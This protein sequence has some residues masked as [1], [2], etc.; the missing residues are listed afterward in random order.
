MCQPFL[1]T[2]VEHQALPSFDENFVQSELSPLKYLNG[3]MHFAPVSG[4]PTVVHWPSFPNF[5]N[6]DFWS[7]GLSQMLIKTNLCGV[8]C[9][10]SMGIARLTRP[11]PSR[12]WFGWSC[13]LTSI[14][15][16]H[17]APVHISI[18][19]ICKD[20]FGN[21]MVN[22][23]KMRGWPDSASC[24]RTVLTLSLFVF[25]VQITIAIATTFDNVSGLFI[26][27]NVWKQNKFT[28]KSECLTFSTSLKRP[29]HSRWSSLLFVCARALVN[30]AP[31]LSIILRLALPTALWVDY[32]CLNWRNIY[33][34]GGWLHCRSNDDCWLVV[35]NA[36]HDSLACLPSFGVSSYLVKKNVKLNIPWYKI[37]PQSI[38]WR[39]FSCSML[40]QSCFC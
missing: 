34:P 1:L 5:G 30:V 22:C 9:L 15:L 17:I 29:E 36:T 2:L 3:K 16:V 10:L 11:D 14:W 19:H 39:R 18:K 38:V 24:A 12:P 33:K 13:V 25:R 32:Q 20:S 37:L 6:L 26:F 40:V 21:K 7:V 28:S 27:W 31:P 35:C 8:T 4:P 23:R